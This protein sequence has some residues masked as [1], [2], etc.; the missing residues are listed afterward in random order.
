MIRKGYVG[1]NIVDGSL[2]KHKQNCYQRV[3]E[4]DLSTFR[5][6]DAESTALSLS[7]IGCSGSG[8]TTTLNRIF[9]TYP[10]VVYHEKYNLTQI[11]YL[12]VDCPHDGELDSLC[13]QFFRALDRVL[14]STY[15]KKHRE[16]N[17]GSTR[18]LAQDVPSGE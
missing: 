4:G 11:S 14:G 9:A 6:Q 10:Q 8:K 17:V 2:N 12:K 1:R 13:F 5:F 16:K 18:L 15:E 3:L 7:F